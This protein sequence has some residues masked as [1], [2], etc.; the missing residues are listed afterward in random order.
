M[1]AKEARVES[2]ETSAQAIQAD[3]APQAV[4][5]T[6]R[7]VATNT[8]GQGTEPANADAEV[9]AWYGGSVYLVT[10]QGNYVADDAPVPP[11]ASAP[12]GHYLTLIVDAYS[13]KIT[14]YELSKTTNLSPKVATIATGS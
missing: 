7:K 14:G 6:T 10:F 5:H 8:I 2:A 13:G 1:A 3:T 9:A 12:T 11:G 4:A